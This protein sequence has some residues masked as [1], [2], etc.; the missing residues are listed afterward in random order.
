MFLK[1]PSL[2]DSA[3]PE[4]FPST[5]VLRRH[6]FTLSRTI[7][8]AVTLHLWAVALQCG[9]DGKRSGSPPVEGDAYHRLDRD[10]SL[11]HRRLVG[12]EGVHSPE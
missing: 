11:E 8:E 9:R 4:R 5:D 3:F 1:R 2:S 6:E 12:T 7:A 10:D